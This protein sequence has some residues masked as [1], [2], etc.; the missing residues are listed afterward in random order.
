MF[1]I[2]Q[3]SAVSAPNSRFQRKSMAK[4]KWFVIRDMVEPEPARFWRD[5]AEIERG[6]LR[7]DEI[8]T[9]DFFFPAAGHAKKEAEFTIRQ[10]LLQWREKAVEPPGDSRSDAWFIHR[11]ALRF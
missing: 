7:T 5:S 4:L 1:L 8:E 10:R 11:V 3:N 6:E 2:A 9:E